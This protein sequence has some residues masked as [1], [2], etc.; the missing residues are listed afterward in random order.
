[1]T[2][3]SS[4]ISL[5]SSLGIFIWLQRMHLYLNFKRVS[6]QTTHSYAWFRSCMCRLRTISWCKWSLRTSKSW[7]SLHWFHARAQSKKRM[8]QSRPPKTVDITSSQ[9]KSRWF[10]QRNLTKNKV[11]KRKRIIG[12]R[13]KMPSKERKL[14]ISHFKH[15]FRINHSSLATKR[16]KRRKKRTLT[17]RILSS[18]SQRS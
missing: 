8:I 9:G 15:S 2:Q 6:Y 18:G 10:T 17:R 11:R 7:Y 1:M 3:K 5:V 12:T 13:T 16:K 4:M 14:F